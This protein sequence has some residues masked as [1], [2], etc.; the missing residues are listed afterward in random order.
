MSDAEKQIDAAIDL[1]NAL[2]DARSEMRY[3]LECA[4]K[5]DA[6]YEMAEEALADL[7]MDVRLQT[8]IDSA[9]ELADKLM[10]ENSCD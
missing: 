4:K 9:D 8:L 3:A 7:D 2:I 1:V 10:A 6:L 5:V